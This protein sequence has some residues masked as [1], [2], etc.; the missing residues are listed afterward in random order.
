MGG[1]A[2]EYD[3][4]NGTKVSRLTAEAVKLLAEKDP[5]AVPDL[6]ESDILDK[7]KANGFA[8][9]LVC[10]QAL[11]FC[12]QCIFRLA[13]GLSASLLELNTLGH[14]ICALFT[15]MLWWSKPLDIEVSH[16]L[17]N[18]EPELLKEQRTANQNQ[19]NNEAEEANK[20][21]DEGAKTYHDLARD[22]MDNLSFLSPQLWGF[23]A[24]TSLLYGGLHLVAWNAPFQTRTQKLLW[25]ISA[26]CIAGAGPGILFITLI[27]ILVAFALVALYEA[28]LEKSDFSCTSAPLHILYWLSV[29]LLTL[30]GIAIVVSGAL[31]YVGA[32]VYIVVEC[33]LSLPYLPDIVFQEPQWQRYFPHIS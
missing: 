9:F 18:G 8:K 25:R 10:A 26:I 19:T 29:V 30:V 16:K 7:S 33:F 5:A 17:D 28:W 1:F 3:G 6:S 24:V 32:R 11:W 31:L 13:V 14:C 27:A 23:L 4:P 21:A 2:Y 22:Q 12:A 20:E 15:Y